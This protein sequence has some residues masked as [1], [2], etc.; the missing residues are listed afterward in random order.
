MHALALRSTALSLRPFDGHFGRLAKY[1][2]SEEREK[3]TPLQIG[4]G[5]YWGGGLRIPAST[6]LRRK[7]AESVFWEGSESL[8][9]DGRG[10]REGG[11]ASGG[12][13][14]ISIGIELSPTGSPPHPVPSPTGGEGSLLYRAGLCNQALAL[15]SWQCGWSA[16]NGLER[17]ARATNTGGTVTLR[18]RVDRSNATRRTSPRNRGRNHVTSSGGCRPGQLRT[19]EGPT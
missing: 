16:C 1:P 3:E 19:G 4:E 12:K 10:V 15:G 11:P 14:S 18:F 5:N 2:R 13:A 9:F 17:R 6:S 7:L 8:S